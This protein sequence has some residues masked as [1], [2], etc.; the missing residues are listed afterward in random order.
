[1]TPARLL[2]EL[3]TV[4]AR[5]GVAL[6][7]ERLGS[8]V[9]GARGGLCRIRGLPLIVIEESLSVADRISVLAGA[10]SGFDLSSIYVPPVV[11]ACIESTMTILEATSVR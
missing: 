10:L 11:R 3:E 8:D 6:R 5:L 9:L 2:S 1:V 7:V 4:A